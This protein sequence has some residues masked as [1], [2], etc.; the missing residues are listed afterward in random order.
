MV[1]TWRVDDGVWQ[2]CG[3]KTLFDTINQI[4]LGLIAAEVSLVV[5]SLDFRFI[6]IS[7]FYF[8]FLVRI[9]GWFCNLNK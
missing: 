2:L 7:L 8:R 9:L 3:L 5:N 4:L 1:M 6:R